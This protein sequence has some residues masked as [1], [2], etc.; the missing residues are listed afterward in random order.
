MKKYALACLLVVVTAVSAFAA[1]L[2]VL[3]SSDYVIHQLY[4]SSTAERNW[5]TDQLGKHII[6]RAE[7][8]T[9]R[10]IPDG[11]YDLRIV[12]EDDNECIVNNVQ[13][14]GNVTWTLTDTVIE[15]CVK[16]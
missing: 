12:D 15:S 11:A 13:V 8:F 5:G 9:L 2:T 1:E 3:N 10:N 16:K 4:V 6:N 14:S 7:R